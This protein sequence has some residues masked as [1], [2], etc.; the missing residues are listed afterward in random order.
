MP[1]RS[2]VQ[3]C[4]RTPSFTVLL[5]LATHFMSETEADQQPTGLLDLPDD[6]LGSVLR[7]QP[8]ADR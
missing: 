7:L 5:M 6:L 4:G 2:M 1:W 8:L 3:A